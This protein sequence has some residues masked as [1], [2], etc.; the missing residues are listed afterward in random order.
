MRVCPQLLTEIQ[1]TIF[2]GCS[3][4]SSSEQGVNLH[5]AGT[6]AIRA[7]VP[8][9]SSADVVTQVRSFMRVLYLTP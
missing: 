7:V 8:H 9:R 6:M 3:E 2:T 1:A 5:L 4:N